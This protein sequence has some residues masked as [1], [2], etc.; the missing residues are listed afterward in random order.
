MSC[1]LC[2]VWEREPEEVLWENPVYAIVRTR[3]LKGHRERVMI[4]AKKHLKANHD[5]TNAIKILIE[6]IPKIFHYTFKA[7]VLD[8]TYGSIPDH[9]H[10]CVTD[11]EEGSHDHEQVLGTPWIGVIHIRNWQND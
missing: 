3:D 9:W 1:P 2:K 5:T 6:E 10:L 7:I 4:V 11:I 8:G